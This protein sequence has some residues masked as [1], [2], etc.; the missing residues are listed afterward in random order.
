[1]RFA[2]EGGRANLHRWGLGVDRTAVRVG[3][4]LSQNL[5]ASL[6]VLAE[7]EGALGPLA[8]DLLTFAVSERFLRLRRALGVARSPT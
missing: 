1:M 4:C 6:G 3:L 8:L 7:E 2:D 5:S